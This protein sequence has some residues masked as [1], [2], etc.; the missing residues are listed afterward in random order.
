MRLYLD[1]N[2]VLALF[3]EDGLSARADDLLAREAGTVVLS[4]LARAEFASVV[5]R[6]VR[7]KRLTR[8]EGLN[9]L[10]RFDEWADERPLRAEVTSADMRAAIA[11]L[12]RFDL[13][14]RSPDAL[15]IAIAARLD[16]TLATF[17]RQMSAA[18]RA[19]GVAVAS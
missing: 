13:A 18:A 1:A 19:L 8:P 14:L 6:H 3:L 17:D 5:A 10:Q 12:R 16:A 9:A 11:A 15:H 2:V 7:T 4:D